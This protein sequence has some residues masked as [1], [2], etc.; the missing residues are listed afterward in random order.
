MK[1]WNLC[2]FVQGCSLTLKI[3]RQINSEME[4]EMLSNL[5]LRRLLTNKLTIAPS[6]SMIHHIIFLL[7]RWF[8]T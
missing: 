2:G 8:I 6:V 1:F 5:M 4:F 7:I 3:D